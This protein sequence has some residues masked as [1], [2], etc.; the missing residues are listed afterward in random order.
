MEVWGSEACPKLFNKEHWTLILRRNR[1][2]LEPR[3]YKA[4][5]GDITCVRQSSI[6]LRFLSSQRDSPIHW[7]PHPCKDRGFSLDERHLE[8]PNSPSHCRLGIGGGKQIWTPQNISHNSTKQ[9]TVYYLEFNSIF[10]FFRCTRS[11]NFQFKKK[12]CCCS[13]LLS[14]PRIQ[15]QQP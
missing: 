5:E 9:S 6:T 12:L 14:E 15:D 7:L 4:K 8:L 2:I 13:I 1:N 10:Y 3:K 11:F